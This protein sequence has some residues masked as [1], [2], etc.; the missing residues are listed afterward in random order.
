MFIDNKKLYETSRSFAPDFSTALKPKAYLQFD[1]LSRAVAEYFARQMV[2]KCCPLNTSTVKQ[3]N[4]AYQTYSDNYVK[5]FAVNAGDDINV[6]QADSAGLAAY[7]A[8]K[9]NREFDPDPQDD[10]PVAS[11]KDFLPTAGW[12]HSC[13]DTDTCDASMTLKNYIYALIAI[14]R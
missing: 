6:M 13:G 2:E 12:E 1:Y 3:R 4:T 8:D 9:V 7:I 10:L 14:N 11:Q 5:E